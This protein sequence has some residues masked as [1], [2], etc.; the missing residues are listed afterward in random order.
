MRRKG[1]S[2]FR[3]LTLYHHLVTMS[4]TRFHLIVISSFTLFNILFALAYVACGAGAL[5]G[6]TATAFG[7]R[8]LEAFFFSVQTS[9]TIGYGHV[10]P[11]GILPNLFVTAE[12]I[13][14]LLGFALATS[15]LFARF[16]RPTAQLLFSN[17]AIVAPYRGI[18]ALEFRMI[19]E[20]TNQLINVE[21]SVTLSRNETVDGRTARKFYTLPLERDEV[22]LMPLNWTVVHPIAEG[23]PLFGVEREE[24]LRSDPEVFVLVTAM[25]ETFAQTVHARTSYRGEETFWD[26]RFADIFERG[27]DGVVTVDLERIH[28]TEP[29]LRAHPATGPNL[30]QVP[31]AEARTPVSR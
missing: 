5:R 20:R 21:V 16:S 6:S 10:V 30:S 9:T 17:S 12:A 27:E 24:Y 3:S 15:L 19:N 14:G 26:M 8:F 25:E 31:A 18:S 7:D 11:D 13:T 22:K 4:W 1:L 29:A 2:L 23:S 28:E